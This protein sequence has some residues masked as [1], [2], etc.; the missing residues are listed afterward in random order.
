MSVS[1]PSLFARAWYHTK[2]T[3]RYPQPL[4][5]ADAFIVSCGQ[6]ARFAL[7]IMEQQCELLRNKKNDE[8]MKFQPNHRCNTFTNILLAFQGDKHTYIQGEPGLGKIELVDNFLTGKHYWK[9]GEPSGFLFGTLPEK[10][11]NRLHLF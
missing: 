11:E 3:Y 2:T 8:R 4:T 6:N 5:K 10:R 9:A 7:P 1:R